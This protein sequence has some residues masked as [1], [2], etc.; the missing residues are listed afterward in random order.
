M[1]CKNTGEASRP[2]ISSDVPTVLTR[3]YLR[4]PHR[5]T[6]QPKAGTDGAKISLSFENLQ[7]LHGPAH[8]QGLN[9]R[10]LPNSI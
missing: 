7:D 8:C 2:D 10:D 6:R 5:Q 1:L 3:T 9:N 4:T